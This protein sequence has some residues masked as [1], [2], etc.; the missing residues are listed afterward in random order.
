MAGIRSGWRW[1]RLALALCALGLL[2]AGCGQALSGANT[3]PPAGWTD[4]TPPDSG[5]AAHYAVSPDIPG[6]IIAAIGGR[7]QA[8]AD[9]PPDA[10]LWRSEDGGASWQALDSLTPRSGSSIFM[11]PGGHGLVISVDALNASISISR[12]AGTSWRTVPLDTSTNANPPQIAWLDGA[13][14]LDGRLYTSSGR[15]FS[16]SEDGGLTWRTIEKGGDA[17]NI[18]P[19]GITAGEATI[20]PL[21][22]SGSAWLRLGSEPAYG[23]GASTIERS[24][25]GGATWRVVSQSLPVA[26]GRVF[27]A[28]LAAN[29]AHPGQICAT[30]TVSDNAPNVA[31]APTV[32]P[33]STAP[34]QPTVSPGQQGFVSYPAPEQKDVALLASDDGG[35]TWRG[36]VVQALRRSFGGAVDPGVQI[37][38]D[39]SCYLATDQQNS[40]FDVG[41]DV[42]ATLWRLAPGAAQPVAQWAMAGRLVESLALAPG[43]AGAAERV[44]ALTRISGPGDGEAASCGSDC[45]TLRDAGAYRLI[46]QPLA[47]RG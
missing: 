1:S 17:A 8:S 21:D 28:Q 15:P 34:P 37:S 33:A 26:D 25:D 7:A 32:T 47:P 12:D 16:V 4:I 30:M 43:G 11:P 39:G 22:A 27:S 36:G 42:L 46:W 6:L 13:V 20:A 24:D 2:L 5:Q 14:A 18:A 38:A 3:A 40:P 19:V 31:T 45:T 44:V 41:P 35:H 29:P 10:R 23:V 9:P